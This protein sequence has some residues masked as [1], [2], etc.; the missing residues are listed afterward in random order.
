MTFELPNLDVM[1]A[2]QVLDLLMRRIAGYAPN[3]TDHNASDPGVTLLQMLVWISEGTAYTA[4]AVPLETYRNMLRWV[5]GISSA[6]ALS[7]QTEGTDFPY[8]KYAD[9]KSQDPAYETLRDMLQNMELG[10][11]I[12][13]A[14]MQAAVVAFRRTPYLAITPADL[15]ALTSELSA[16]IDA[17]AKPQTTPLHVVRL[18]TNVRGDVTE[19]YIVNDAAYA[20]SQTPRDDGGG[21]FSISLTSVIEDAQSAEV[22]ALLDAVREYLTARTVMGGMLAIRNARLLY[23]D[24]QCKVRCFARE[25]ADEVAADVLSALEKALQPVRRDGGR[26]WIYGS[27]IDATV[28]MPLIAAVPGVDRVESLTVALPHALPMRL[29]DP[30]RAEANL[31]QPPPP[32]NRG[33]VIDSGLPRLRYASVTA[34]EAGNG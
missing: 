21:A 13:Y 31:F 22:V 30:H 16:Y 12:R 23:L 4:N 27:A 19:L 8:A 5:L 11:R 17:M 15:S 3:W 10:A 20:Y 14:A 29:R 7:P 9:K 2:D 34:V 1:N 18:C 33:G 28:L 24:V 6:L 26:D 25:R 32:S